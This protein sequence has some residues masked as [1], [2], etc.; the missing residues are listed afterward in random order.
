VLA[1]CAKTDAGI[2]ARATTK[3]ARR[4]KAAKTTQFLLGDGQRRCEIVSGGAVYF[5][6]SG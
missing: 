6:K 4:Q 2:E 5:F 3:H 1:P